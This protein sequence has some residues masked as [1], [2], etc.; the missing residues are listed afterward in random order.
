[1]KPLRDKSSAG[2]TLIEAAMT[3][4]IVGMT[5][6][7]VMQALEG[8]KL[9][10]AHTLNAKL[11]R[12]LGTMT[13]G[14]IERGLWWDDIET[15]QSGSY[16][17]Q[18][19]PEFFFELALGEETFFEYDEREDPYRQFDTW[20]YQRERELENSDRA[21]DEE[22]EEATEPYEK[23]RIRITFPKLRNF[24]NDIVL[25]RWIPWEQVYGK[26]EEEEAEGE[27]G[28]SGG[29]AGGAAPGG[30]GSGSGLEPR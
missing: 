23:V 15:L 5:L 16:A 19:H 8:A 20:A 21:G 28:G 2:F 6:S 24:D 1:M 10:A 22:D 9:T 25:E 4:A 13:L 3:I 26:D 30:V 14:E 11:A 17:D 18:D 29:G 12:E 7:A 27:T